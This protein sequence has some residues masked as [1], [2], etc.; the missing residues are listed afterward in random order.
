MNARQS[1]HVVPSTDGTDVS[2]SAQ[3]DGFSAEALA[4]VPE[5]LVRDPVLP[6]PAPPVLPALAAAD[7]TRLIAGLTWKVASGPETPVMRK[8][9][10][11]VLRLPDRRAELAVDEG[12]R[13]GSLLLS[14]AADL[15]ALAAKDHGPWAF[16]AELPE[17]EDAPTIWM[18]IADIAATGGGT[19]EEAATTGAAR[20]VTPR[21]GPESMFDDPED[22]LEALRAHLA[23]LDLAGLAVRWH[24]G[25]ETRRGTMIKGIAEVATSLPLHDVGPEA[26]C[27]FR[28]V[29]AER[30]A[31]ERLPVFTRPR[32]VPVRLLALLGTGTAALLAGVFVI[33]PTIEDLFRVPPPPPPP[34]VT[35][36]VA[37]GAFAGACTAALEAWWPR[38]TGWQVGIAG[39][40][41][42]G[43]LPEKPVLPEPE[44]TGRTVRPLVVWRQLVPEP[45]RNQVLA[46]AAADQMIATW[47]DEARID[48]NGLALWRTES[49]P[50]VP[51]QADGS[52]E[53]PAPEEIRA[54]LAALWADAPT[55]VTRPG[56][57]DGDLITIKTS[58]AMS[59]ATMFA[60][61]GR[62]HGIAPAR[63][64]R[65]A[66]GTGEL[67]LTPVSLR[68]MPATLFEDTDGDGGT[69]G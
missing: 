4:E 47:P 37:P 44:A 2:V 60:R 48:E 39:C 20:E 56:D 9:A 21:P 1:L 55:A 30:T 43:H 58:G 41:L 34:T 24:P 32:Q 16:I 45:G 14:M 68:E 65:S 52:G 67:V 33:L 42:A 51:T 17:P 62:V 63:F 40:A 36:Q 8:N 50:L 18:G 23:A 28:D 22:A 59:A 19:E 61:A 11:S 25:R 31:A 69:S 6:I 57:G 38:V 54:R 35:V 26:A 7:G 13:C 64:A 12:E 3:E 5:G 29:A 10:P 53:Q 66:D 27:P 49:L 46:R 15:P